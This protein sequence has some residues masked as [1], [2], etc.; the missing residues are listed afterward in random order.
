MAKKGFMA[1]IFCLLML[2]F[3]GCSSDFDVAADWKEISIVYG[4]LSVADD[5]HYIRINKA[6]LDEKTSAF[7]MAAI[8]DSLHH[9]GDLTVVLEEYDLNDNFKK[10][11]DFVKTDAESEGMNKEE[12][13]FANMPFFLYKAD[14][15]L[16]SDRAYTLNIT[17]AEGNEVTAQTGMVGDFDIPFPPLDFPLSFLDNSTVSWTPAENARIYEI[18]LYVNYDEAINDS[19]STVV[20]RKQL[21]WDALSVDVAEI[22]SGNLV[23]ELSKDG[24]FD[25]LIRKLDDEEVANLEYREIASLDLAIHAATE[26]FYNYNL[27][28]GAQF[29]ITAGQARPTYTN[30]EG[31][32]AGLFTSRYT[33]L[34]Q[35][36]KLNN[37]TL[38]QIACGEETVHLK[39]RPSPDTVTYPNC[40]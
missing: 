38:E 5:T 7:E 1:G 10:S 19:G 36:L 18:D 6:F 4:L 24:F 28:A 2:I 11:I 32:A 16:R 8:A 3:F 33:K 37:Q 40:P 26:D 12:G 34:L 22:G 39:F 13:D 29:G 27:V 17:T 31:D 14:A 30:L 21:K 15:T 20:T 35:D 9:N 23:Q 25:F